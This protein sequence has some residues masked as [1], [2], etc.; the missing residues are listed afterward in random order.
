MSAHMKIIYFCG[1]YPY[2]KKSDIS[3]NQYFCGG[4]IVAAFKIVNEIVKKNI[5]CYVFTTSY[6]RKKHIEKDQNLEIIHYPTTI[7]LFSSNISWGLIFNPLRYS[8]DI[9]HV[10]FDL[11]PTPFCGYRYA[12]KK[13][14]PLVIT[15]HGDWSDNYGNIFRKL[16]VKII[17]HLLV[18][19]M[20]SRADILISP[21][22]YYINESKFLKKYEKKVRI[23]PNGVDIEQFKVEKSKSDCKKILGLSETSIVVLFLGALT[24][25]KG[26]EVL[27]KSIK[28]VT[29]NDPTVHLLICGTGEMESSLKNLVKSLHLEKNVKFCGFVDENIKHIYYNS[30]DMFCLPSTV[31]T[32]VFPLVLLE[33]S[34]CGLPLV[35]SDLET[36]KCIVTD[37]YNGFFTKKG[38]ERD[39]AEKIDYLIHHEKE[40]LRLGSNARLF[41]EQFSWLKI[42]DITYD[43]Y[44]ELL[45]IKKSG[46]M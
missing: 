12:M 8:A 17:N 10:H 5:E 1:K 31:S 4:S 42:A 16:I 45:G 38:D 39:L 32:E 21:S 35:V 23:I 6:N 25:R 22:Q 13:N 24:P 28:T 20:L 46:D 40:R 3:D 19:K 15:Y 44:R 18:D 36:F 2:S 7:R 26:P 34:A 27:I 11:P 41:A 43:C 30:A 37:G 14:K 33:A 29:V 9:V